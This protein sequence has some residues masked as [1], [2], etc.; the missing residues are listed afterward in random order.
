M[1]NTKEQTAEILY[2]LFDILLFKNTKYKKTVYSSISNY[3]PSH[4][5]IMS[6]FDKN[7]F[8]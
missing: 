7:I 2:L 4:N 5:I 8:N 6:L 1:C 3:P